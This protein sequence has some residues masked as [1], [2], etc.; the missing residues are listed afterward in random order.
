MT[1]APIARRKLENA[2]SRRVTFGAGVPDDGAQN[3]AVTLG[4]DRQPVF[5]IPGRKTPFIGIVAEFNLALFQRLAIGRTDDR[6]Q[7]AAARSIGQYVPVDVERYRMRRGWTPFQHVQPPWIIGEMHSD[8][9]GDEIE[10]QPEVVL[11][12]R[13]A[14]SLKAG[15][16]AK[17]RI[18]PGMIDD[19]IAVGRALAGLHEGRGIEMRNAERFQIGDDRRGRVEIEVRRQL[20]AVGRVRD[21][22]RHHRPPMRHNNDQGGTKSQASPPQIGVPFAALILCEISLFER[23]ATSSSLAPPPMRQWAVSKPLAAASA[24]PKDVPA[25][26]G[27]ISRRRI[28]RRFCTSASRFFPGAS[29]RDSQSSIAD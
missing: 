8:M 16:A 23:L 11:L 5:E 14:Q 20:D 13:I 29:W 17:L 15:I 3:L 21:G 1:Q 27:T 12:E 18:D 24:S 6:Q 26:L 25:S 22:R 7:H 4:R 10:Y 9:V 2:F 28:A 19:V